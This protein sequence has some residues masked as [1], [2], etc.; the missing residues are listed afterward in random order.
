MHILILDYLMS[1]VHLKYDIQFP[2]K[3]KNEWAK[4]NTSNIT[5]LDVLQIWQNNAS[6]PG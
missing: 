5:V 4:N 1:S 6:G 2:L 3:D